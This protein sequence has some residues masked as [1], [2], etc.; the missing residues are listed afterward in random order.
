MTKEQYKEQMKS[1][2]DQRDAI[3][4]KICQLNDDYIQAN[5]KCN[6]GD[7][8]EVR[9]NKNVEKG[10]VTDFT[11]HWLSEEVIPVLKKMKKD[12]TASAHSLRVW[13]GY[14]IIYPEAATPPVEL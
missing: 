3:Q 2:S 14:E 7:V 5:K 4:D 13:S 11:I 10:V 12:G 9:W 6:V 1:L 8:V